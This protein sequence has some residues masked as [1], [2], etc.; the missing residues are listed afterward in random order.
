MKELLPLKTPF[1]HNSSYCI[2]LEW[3]HFIRINMVQWFD[4]LFQN[5]IPRLEHHE[6]N[7]IYGKSIHGQ[8]FLYQNNLKDLDPSVDGSRF[9]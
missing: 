7:S 3:G 2:S 6:E 5:C 9:L 4:G 8:V 1:Y